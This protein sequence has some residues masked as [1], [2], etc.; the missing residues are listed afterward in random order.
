MAGRAPGA[1]ELARIPA[2]ALT[3]D[4][5]VHQRVAA[6]PTHRRG[7]PAPGAPD[8]VSDRLPERGMDPGA[9]LLALLG[10]AEPRLAPRRLPPVRLDGRG[11]HRRRP[12]SR[13]G[14]PAG[15]GHDQ[16]ARGDDRRQPGRRG[17][18]PVA[19]RGARGRRG[20]PQ[21]LDHRRPAARRDE[22]PQLRRPDP[23]RGVLAAVARASAA[24]PTR[25][26]RSGCPVTGGNVS[27]Y[28]ESPDGADRA[29]RRRSASSGCSTTSRRS[30]VRR[31]RSPTTRSSSSARRCPGLAGSAYAELA[32]NA[33]EDD[34]PAL[35]LA[36]EA[37]LQAF[38]REAIAPGPR[39]V[40]PGR[41]GRRARR[42]PRR[43][44]DVGR[45]RGQ[46]PDP[47]RALAGG[48]PVRREP[49]AAR[50]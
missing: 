14:G 8:A 40:G 42:R 15:Q 1:R 16:G 27:L 23:A 44:R 24:W 49:V 11:G 28:N 43:M 47:G 6:A 46:R 12:G 50:R 34:P 45:A 3:S 17:A 32:G 20:D 37:A 2:R 33:A 26:G 19:R 35:D 10:S 29:D 41:L 21:R 30:S 39:G 13:R 22:L 36:R 38:I 31:S 5:I 25:A 7:A 9:V 18:R 48:R 4:A